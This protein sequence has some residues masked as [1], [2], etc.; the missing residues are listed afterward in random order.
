MI[1][2]PAEDRAYTLF[3]ETMDRS[4]YACGTLEPRTGMTA[5][6]PARRPRPLRTMADMGMQMDHGD[7]KGMDMPGTKQNAHSNET[8]S[9][10]MP[11]V[12]YSGG[13]QNMEH[14]QHRAEMKHMQGTHDMPGMGQHGGDPTNEHL[15]HDSGIQ[16]MSGMHPG[17]QQRSE[18][19]GT[20]PVRHGPDHHGTGN[21]T[22]AE[23]SQNRMGEP[24]R[25]LEGSE[26]RVLLYTDLKSLTPY[27]DQREPER[28]IELHL[29][30]HMERYLWSFDGKK[31]SEAKEPIHFRYSERVRFT[32]CKRHDDGASAASSRHV[33][34]P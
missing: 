13:E 10:G 8:S 11:S 5:D 23:Y 21:Q 6:I 31:Y 28:E 7:M 14:D 1:A 9:E 30:G 29:T 18:I 33:D 27:S 22:V 15:Q 34:A 26:R 25:G 19:P 2:E 32:F 4:G 16:D 12:K 20:E 24:G 17:D 3:A